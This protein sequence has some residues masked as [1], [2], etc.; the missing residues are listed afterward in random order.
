M[1]QTIRPKYSRRD[2]VWYCSNDCKTYKQA[3]IV[4]M[5]IKIQLFDKDIEIIT[6]VEYMV[7]T[8]EG[9]KNMYEI[10]LFQD[11]TKLINSLI[12]GCCIYCKHEQIVQ[13]R[14]YLPDFN[15]TCSNCF[16]SYNI[17]KDFKQQ[18]ENLKKY[19]NTFNG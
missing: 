4:D 3:T 12:N 18:I 15:I 7:S 2:S 6:S 1:I 11:K 17:K 13:P 5:D 14:F 9:T 10:Q 19:Q 8:E 16:K